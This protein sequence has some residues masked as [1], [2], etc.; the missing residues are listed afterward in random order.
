MQYLML[1]N[2]HEAGVL[3]LAGGVRPLLGNA[4]AE[5]RPLVPTNLRGTFT[6]FDRI[7]RAAGWLVLRSLAALARKSCKH[8]KD[9][10]RHAEQTLRPDADLSLLLRAQVPS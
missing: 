7:G 1:R 8:E 2:A 9:E 4:H 3:P 10:P 6:H 5:L